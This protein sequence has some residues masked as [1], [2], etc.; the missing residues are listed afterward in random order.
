VQEVNNALLGAKENEVVQLESGDY[1]FGGVLDWAGVSQR[2]R[3][4]ARNH[5]LRV[6]A[7]MKNA[8]LLILTPRN[9]DYREQQARSR[10]TGSSW[11]EHQGAAPAPE[12]I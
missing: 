8:K 7:L 2:R 10:V 5:A 12:L 3:R 9:E 6:A 1:V 4:L 11:A